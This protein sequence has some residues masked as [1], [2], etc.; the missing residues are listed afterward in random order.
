MTIHIGLIGGGNIS[1]THARAATAIPEV[2]IS[3]VYGINQE[4]VAGL[5]RE[6]GAQPDR[7]SVV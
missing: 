6:V 7:K 3:A 5:C 1:L 4:K 2:K